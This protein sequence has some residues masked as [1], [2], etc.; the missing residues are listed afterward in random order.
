MAAGGEVWTATRVLGFRGGINVSTLGEQRTSAS[1]G[2][3]VSVRPRTFV[4]AHLSSGERR[5]DQMGWGVALR[6]TF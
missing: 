2:I 5:S 1:G 6:V 3:S 4:D